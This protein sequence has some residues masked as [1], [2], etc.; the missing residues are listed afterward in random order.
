LLLE[1][2]ANNNNNNK[3]MPKVASGR[4]EIAKNIK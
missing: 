3:T 1:N 4:P 2:G